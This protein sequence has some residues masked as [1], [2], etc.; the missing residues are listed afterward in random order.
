V[1]LGQAALQIPRGQAVRSWLTS[2]QRRALLKKPIWTF[3]SATLALALPS[4]SGFA[5]LNALAL[6]PGA[7]RIW[8]RSVRVFAPALISD[9]GEEQD[10]GGAAVAR[11]HATGTVR[12]PEMDDVAHCGPSRIGRSL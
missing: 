2:S 12:G 7:L 8:L 1:E 9:A 10:L 5:N 6:S 4:P 11:S 3:L